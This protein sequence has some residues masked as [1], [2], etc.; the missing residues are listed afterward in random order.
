M[1]FQGDFE[2]ILDWL[3]KNPQ[4]LVV[5]NIF[6]KYIELFNCDKNSITI[7][8][9][10][11][12]CKYDNCVTQV[13]PHE[14][15]NYKITVLKLQYVS[16]FRSECFSRLLIFKVAARSVYQLSIRNCITPRLRGLCN[17]TGTRG[18]ILV[19]SMV[20]ILENNPN[21]T[22]PLSYNLIFIFLS[23]TCSGI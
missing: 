8:Q 23:H 10:N 16:F 4:I 18:S 14:Y 11:L 1:A 5:T 22:F 15:D 3:K 21:M 2:R 13:K 9:T 7:F 17:K 19:S 6:E 20:L 12:N